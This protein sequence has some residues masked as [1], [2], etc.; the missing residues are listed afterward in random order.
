MDT[1]LQ[2]EREKDVG[3]ESELEPGWSETATTNAPVEDEVIQ[4]VLGWTKNASSLP[5]II[6]FFHPLLCPKISPSHL[7]PPSYLPPTY[8]PPTSLPPTSPPTS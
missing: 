5:K 7:P 4:A 1:L 6:N 8:H 2:W 3:P